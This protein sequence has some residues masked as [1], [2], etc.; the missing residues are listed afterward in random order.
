MNVGDV[1]VNRLWA[2]QLP[3]LRTISYLLRLAWYLALRIWRYD[4]VHVHIAALNG[5]VAALATRIARRPLYIKVACGGERGE[6]ARFRRV[7]R[8]THWFGL[9]NAT[10]QVLSDEI[11]REMLSI[12]VA[13]GRIV[14]IP[15]GIDLAAF[16]PATDEARRRLRDELDIPPDA[17][18]VLFTGRFAVYKGVL[19]L[20]E[21]WALADRE[22]SLLL[23]IGTSITDDWA[24]EL[25][26]RSSV[27]VRGWTN[28]VTDYL[29]AADIFVVPSHADGMSNSMLEAMACGLP[30][31]A[32]RVASA[33][34]LI[35][36]GQTGLLV[37]PKRPDQL[38]RAIEALTTDKQLRSSLGANAANRVRDLAI[39]RVV[40]DIE[41]VYEQ[42]VV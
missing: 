1:P 21:A 25:P 35:E 32:T 7:A 23:M 42:I 37:E 16:T 28:R 4:I 3:K 2:V 33:G 22:D 36:H 15:N 10:V 26:K 40:D 9:R 8:F 14:R 30:V 12:G 27:E 29:R 31:I 39:E 34:T 20:L 13:P 38:A 24:G 18:I 6:V 5:D 11:E 19:D 17:V 41:R